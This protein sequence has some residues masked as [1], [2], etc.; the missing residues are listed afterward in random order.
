ML[1]FRATSLRT[2]MAKPMRSAAVLMPTK[3]ASRVLFGAC[4]ASLICNLSHLCAR[5]HNTC[6]SNFVVSFG[7]RASLV[8]IKTAGAHERQCMACKIVSGIEQVVALRQ[9]DVA[10]LDILV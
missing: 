1:A 10:D 4:L 9:G 3:D 8:Y 7:G 5:T 6:K 2:V